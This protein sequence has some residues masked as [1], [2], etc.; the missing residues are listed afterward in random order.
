MLVAE[1]KHLKVT[2]EGVR[3]HLRALLKAGE[4][5]IVG[6]RQPA[7]GRGR[8]QKIYQATGIL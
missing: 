1:G 2:E 5:K 7:V 3:L 4:L 8:G 6:A